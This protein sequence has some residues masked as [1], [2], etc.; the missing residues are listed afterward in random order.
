MEMEISFRS[1]SHAYHIALTP[2][3]LDEMTPADTAY[4]WDREHYGRPYSEALGRHGMEAGISAGGGGV[5]NYVRGHLD[6]WRLFHFH[7]T[8]STSPM[9]RSAD[10]GD[11]RFLRPDGANLAAYLYFLRRKHSDAYKLILGAVRLV[12]PF[13]KDFRLEPLRLDENKVR[14]EWVHEDS[15]VS[16]DAS[17]LS[18][19]TIR[20][21]GVAT[22]LLQ[23]AELRPTVILIDEP[24]LGLHPYAITLLASLMKQA[25]ARSQLIV[26]TQSPLL[27]DHFEPEDVLV[28]DLK[29]GATQLTRLDSQELG[30]WLSDFS[31]GQLWEKNQ[32]GG[33]PG[34]ER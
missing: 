11:N 7:D 23:P 31:L 24:E 17:A 16:F 4:Y 27:L 30:E 12:A 13:L 3:E 25:S 20:F 18:D 9:K 8:S 29:D 28:A 33:R 34:S 19:G 15:D 2:T 6:S 1:K 10:V 14:L 5:A 22:L 32:F 26:A 21:V